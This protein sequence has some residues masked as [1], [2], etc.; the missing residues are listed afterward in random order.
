MPLLASKYP[1]LP[2]VLYMYHEALDLSDDKHR[3]QQPLAVYYVIEILSG[4]GYKVAVFASYPAIPFLSSQ[5]IV[6]V[7]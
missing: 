6:R 1:N 5:M 7:R 3:H 4:S 2:C